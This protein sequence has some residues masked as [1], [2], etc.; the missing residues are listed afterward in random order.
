VKILNVIE[1]MN[2][3]HGGPVEVILTTSAVLAQLGHQNEVVSP[4]RPD[5]PWVAS[6]P[7]PHH[8]LGRVTRKYG[9]S[10]NF[11]KWMRDHRKDYDVVIIHGVWSYATIGAWRGLSGTDTP[12]FVFT[13]GMLDP[14]FGK[15]APLKNI[16]KQA[17]WSLLLGR[18]LADARTVLFTAEEERRLARTAFWG[19]PYRERVVAFGTAD[20]SGDAQ[21]Q[22]AAFRAHLPELNNRRILLFLSRIHPKKGCDLLVRAFAS[23]A[24]EQPDLDLV[25]AGPDQVGWRAELEQIG[26]RLGLKGRIHWPGMLSGDVKWGAFR[27]AEAFVLPSHQENF[28]IV[29]AEAMA[30]RTPVLITDKVNIW[31][32]VQAS[33]GGLVASDDE[34]GVER[35]LREFLGLTPEAR[36]R[37]GEAARQGFLDRFDVSAAA[38]ELLDTIV[39]LSSPAPAGVLADADAY[40]S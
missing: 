31:A 37:M 11:A 8:A 12:Y 21:D 3:A 16:A 1:S 15:V 33:G 25:I 4:D 20:V 40:P 26:E 36:R 22:I 27:A 2:P 18:V 5:D 24:G 34:A 38:R 35:L 7:L 19:H 39:E 13:H 9:Y 14:W 23:I 30:C 6:S 32:E 29:V 10:P 17:Y 28:G